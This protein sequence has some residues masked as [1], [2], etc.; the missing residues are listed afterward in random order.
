[1]IKL[2]PTTLHNA[3]STFPKQ[4]LQ[5]GIF[6][7]IMLHSGI[8]ANAQCVPPPAP[9]VTPNP[10]FMCL[11]GPAVKLKVTPGSH[12]IP[13]IWTPFAG[14]YYDPAATT[15]YTGLPVD[16]VWARPAPAGT[17][18]Y[19]VT[20]QNL[21][22]GSPSWSFS[23][24]T[25]ISIPIGGAAAPYPSNVVVAGLPLTG[26]RV[27]SVVLN[28]LSHT[29]PEDLDIVLISPSG[30][31]V[32][33]MSDAGGTTSVNN[34]MYTFAD[35]G[36]LLTMGAN[37]TG[38]Y[39]P[40]N[41]GVP[42]LFPP[43][44]PNMVQASPPLLSMFIGNM[45]GTW[46]LFITDD[47]A[48]A[49]LG[50]IAGGYTINF[51]TASTACVSPPTNVIVNVG[52]PSTITAQPTDQNVCLGND[53]HFTVTA[54]NGLTYNWQ[55]STNGG[56]SWNNLVNGG[57]YSGINT[58]SLT[59]TAPPFAMNGY[60]YRVVINGGVGCGGAT[61]NAAVLTVNLLPTV[62]ITAFPYLRILPGMT[63]TLYSNVTPNP[64]ATYT[65]FHNAS[66]VPGANA[67]TLLVDFS[68]LGLYQ[69]TVTDINGCTNVS[70]TLRIRDSA[71]RMSLYPNPST[72]HFQVRLYSDANSILPLK[73]NVYNNM[74]LKLVSKSYNQTISYE[75]IYIDVRRNGKGFY[76]VEII[77]KEGKR[78]ALS[79]VL[80]Q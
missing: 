68:G 24:T 15:P 64:A 16:S 51:D 47:D 76:W 8:F 10:A 19:Q 22:A 69:L 35:P 11:G 59:I 66:V 54:T 21:P 73:I 57:P 50:S 34:V 25:P 72:G 3:T 30:Q 12:T 55:Q 49:G 52:V 60:R 62:T 40:T 39:R 18:T 45:N 75:S 41:Y 37:P 80:V 1:M 23:N 58:A 32:L 63:T 79:K 38:I 67:D 5:K 27:K 71:G 33:L 42:D 17:Y 7:L 28:N 6:L 31:A 26:F 4:F 29:K 53:A 20:T 77:D 65:W 61:S 70:D 36:P 48:S 74:G 56:G 14:L 2:Y 44:G 13:G 46:S 43:P 78:M 9:V